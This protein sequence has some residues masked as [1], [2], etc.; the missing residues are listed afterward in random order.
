MAESIEISDDGTEHGEVAFDMIMDAIA[1]ASDQ[2]RSTWVLADGKR[3]AYIT[4]VDVGEEHE[5]ALRD[6]LGSSSRIVLPGSW[7]GPM[8]KSVLDPPASR[9]P[10]GQG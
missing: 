6:L 8:L 5:Q 2:D 3:I 9:D 1:A 4:T 10:G 7:A